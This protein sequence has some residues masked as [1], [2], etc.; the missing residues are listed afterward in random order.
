MVFRLHRTTSH[1]TKLVLAL[2]IG[3]LQYSNTLPKQKQTK[4]C[5]NKTTTKIWTCRSF[6]VLSEPSKRFRPE[7]FH[8]NWQLWI[9]NGSCEHARPIVYGQC[10]NCQSDKSN[11]LPRCYVL[12]ESGQWQASLWAHLEKIVKITMFMN[13]VFTPLKCLYKL[14][15]WTIM[16]LFTRV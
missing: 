6:A 5:K 11:I 1:R 2:R 7:Q 8:S 13:N 3:I 10:Q 15:W 12:R 14:K 16:F 4:K 9:W